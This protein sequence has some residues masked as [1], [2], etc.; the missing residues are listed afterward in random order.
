MVADEA[1]LKVAG[2]LDDAGTVDREKP[3]L[4]AE[5]GTVNF[6]LFPDIVC[7]FT[8]LSLNITKLY[9]YSDYLDECISDCSP[10]LVSIAK[11]ADDFES[12]LAALR[13]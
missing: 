10:F 8:L 13:R 4:N 9:H 7:V 3:Q 12:R 1:G 2:L 5:E 6:I 11:P